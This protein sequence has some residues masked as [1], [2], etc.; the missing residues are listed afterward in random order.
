MD[1]FIF[2]IRNCH[3][4][5]HEAHASV[6]LHVSKLWTKFL[7]LYFGDINVF[8]SWFFL[9]GTIILKKE[10]GKPKMEKEKK[11]EVVAKHDYIFYLV[12]KILIIY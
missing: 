6:R 12:L 5:A 10:K 8:L 7:G 2:Y 3:V 1:H 11:R 9:V 4:D